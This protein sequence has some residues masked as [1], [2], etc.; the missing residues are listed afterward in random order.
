ML[1]SYPFRRGLHLEEDSNQLSAL[2]QLYIYFLWW[3]LCRVLKYKD[4]SNYL[5][6]KEII[7]SL[8][9]QDSVGKRVCEIIE[10]ATHNS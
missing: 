2:L 8:F 4:T 3:Q 5:P 7:T 1:Q 6:K 10:D 9:G